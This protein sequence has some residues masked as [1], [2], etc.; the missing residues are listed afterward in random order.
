M[1][2]QYI[3][4]LLNCLENFFFTCFFMEVFFLLFRYVTKCRF[5]IDASGEVVEGFVY[6]RRLHKSVFNLY[7]A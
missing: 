1:F 4:N 2:C 6:V 3:T 5:R 7:L